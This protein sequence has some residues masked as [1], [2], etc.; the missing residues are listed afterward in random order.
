[1][2]LQHLKKPMWGLLWTLGV[3]NWPKRVRKLSFE[4]ATSIPWLPFLAVE[5]VLTIISKSISNLRSP[6]LFQGY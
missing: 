6:L 1:M 2:R 5:D 4:I 3:V